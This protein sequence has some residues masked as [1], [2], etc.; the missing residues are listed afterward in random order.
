G[1]TG[2]SDSEKTKPAYHR[3]HK[4]A[5]RYGGAELQER[6]DH[7]CFRMPLKISCDGLARF[8]QPG[9]MRSPSETDDLIKGS[10][11]EQCVDDR[12]DTRVRPAVSLR[13][14]FACFHESFII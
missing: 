9:K 14:S 5:E 7:N 11:K 12:D 6:G 4:D 8:P 2:C 1:R 10:I 13:G 3:C